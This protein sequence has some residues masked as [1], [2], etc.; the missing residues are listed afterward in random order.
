MRDPELVQVF[1][2]AKRRIQR[3]Q[4]TFICYALQRVADCRPELAKAVH[5]AERLISYRMRG[6]EAVDPV[7]QPLYC[8]LYDYYR[9]Q[10]VSFH[11]PDADYDPLMREYRIQWLNHLIKEFS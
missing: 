2:L 6:Y 4:D 11:L 8:W 9:S 3:R 10:G 7:R 1:R 5:K